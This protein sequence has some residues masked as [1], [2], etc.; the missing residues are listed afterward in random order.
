MTTSTDNWGRWGTDDEQGAAN[1]LTPEVRLAAL[2]VPRSGKLYRL[3]SPITRE[4]LPTVPYR[5]AP[6][7]LTLIND[8]DEPMLEAFGAPGG[9]GSVEDVVQFGSHTGTHMDAL[10]HIYAD[11]TIYNG[12]ANTEQT[13]WGGAARCGIEKAGPLLTRGV[14]VD[15]AGHQGVPSLAPGHVISVAEFDAAAQAQG[16][17][18]QP[19]DAVLVR[20]GWYEAFR[21]HDGDV[22]PEQPGIGLQLAQHLGRADVAVVGADNTAVEA[23]PF[24]AGGF[25]P[26]HIELLVRRGVYLIEHLRLEDLAADGCHTFLFAVA[27]LPVV[28]ATASPVDPFAIG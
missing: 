25:V 27:P 20:T 23:M 16:V 19:G 17:T 22:A 5:T 3:G 1:L 11:G 21:N 26:V 2:Q 24:D 4:G 18:L 8:R 12:F 10:S 14:L 7:R 28:G 9:I 13:T 6:Q 15:V